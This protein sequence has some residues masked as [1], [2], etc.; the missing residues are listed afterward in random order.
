MIQPKL[1]PLMQQYFSIKSEYQEALLLF[2]VGDFY[3]LFF[4]DAKK[5]AAFLAITLTKRGK[6]EGQDIPLCG[7]PVHAL[8]HYLV[9]LIKGG[10]KV[11]IVDQVTKP[12]PGQV[13]ERRV[14]RF[15]TPGT[16]TDEH[17]MDQKSPS[18]LCVMYPGKLEW[19]IVF[20]E[21]LTA[22]T[23]ATVVP[24]GA[25]R[26]VDAEMIRFF[27][28][29]ILIP[30]KVAQA[31]LAAYC[32]QRGYLVSTVA[33][34]DEQSVDTQTWLSEQI[35]GS[36]KPHLTAHPALG[37][38]LHVLH[39]YLAKNH[40]AVLASMKTIQY[41][42]PEDFLVLDAAT[43][44]NLEIVTSTSQN[45]QH[46]LLGVLDES[47]TPMGARTIKKWLLRP[48]VN[49]AHI[50]QRQEVVAALKSSL[51]TMQKLRG[52]LAKIADL[53]RIIGRIAL[54]RATIHDYLALYRSLLVVPEIKEM[55]EPLRPLSLASMMYDKCIDYSVLCELLGAS[56]NDDPA[57][58]WL[59][60]PGF[61]FELDQLRNLVLNGQ[62]ELLALEQRE[63]EKT[64]IG[65][66]KVRYTDLYGY[67]F[68]ITKANAESVPEHY[69]LQQSLSNRSRYVTPEL[70]ELEAA[71]NRATQ[72]IEQVEKAVFERI[73]SEVAP[74][75]GSLRHLAHALA[76]LDGLASFAYVA[77]AYN[78]IA[79]TFN[80]EGTIDIAAGRHPVVERT[81]SR[82][83]PNH[84]QLSD[85]EH[86]HIITGPNMGGKSTYLRQIGLIH[87][88]AQC[89]SFVPAQR[90]N[91]CVLDRIF[92]RIGSGDDVAGGKSTFLVEM[93]E[94]AV[95]CTQA[96][97]RSLVILDEVGRGT[98]TYDGMALAQAII[99]Y[100]ATTLKARAFFATHY[101]ELTALQD[102][103][104]G[105]QNYHLAVKKHADSLVFLHTVCQGTAAGSFGLEVAKLAHVP[106]SIIVRARAILQNLSASH[107]TS[108][109]HEI[110]DHQVVPAVSV[111]QE[112]PLKEYLKTIDLDEVSPRQA[113]DLLYRLKAL[114]EDI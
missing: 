72:T 96:T 15:L 48:L 98:S 82:F 101:H 68:E 42:E 56:I 102:T 89:G 13:V 43:Q 105:I 57:Q 90:A 94:T 47:V 109:S 81:Q 31:E 77:Y 44:K 84:T 78:Y 4:D 76:L 92:T 79:P 55:L 113:V 6:S 106:E 16:L 104:P 49:T 71:I 99:E 85:A 30:N 75:V 107:S 112:N 86:V 88:L 100:I 39:Q 61:D 59:I 70:K 9:K 73:K 66:L 14:T 32:R 80:E 18:Y 114:S 46:S 65:S 41:Y 12:Q 54:G 8:H 10:F 91:L 35:Q 62:Q 5:A 50:M 110:A 74:Y 22:Q 52:H 26:M 7:I 29:E 24:A 108:K 1:T 40:A 17:L 58:T 103:C 25:I 28:D 63:I 36:I 53:E 95:I 38:T 87:V 2:Q 97:S 67:A 37:T 3:E 93:E 69:V 19:G 33:D 20:T 111:P 45:T 23:F 83:V 60:K 34:P 27:P 51:T 64:G 21:L 11:A